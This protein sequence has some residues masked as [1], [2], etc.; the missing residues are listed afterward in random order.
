MAQ[1]TKSI[2]FNTV[3]L[4]E[5]CQ[6]ILLQED[7]DVVTLI[8]EQLPDYIPPVAVYKSEPSSIL[9]V[10][11]NEKLPYILREMCEYLTPGTMVY[12]SSSSEEL[13]DWIDDEIIE[14]MLGKDIDSAVC[15]QNNYPLKEDKGQS[16]KD[17]IIN[18]DHRNI[19]ELLSE[20]KPNY[21][22]ILTSDTMDDELADEQALK[23]LLYCTH[24]KHLHPAADFGIT[25]EMRTVANQQLAQDSMANDFVISRNIASL[26][27]AQ[28]A[29]SREL[30][31]IFEV[32]LR[33]EG[34]EIY[35]KPVK[36]YFSVRPDLEIDFYSV[37]DAVAEK[38]EIFIGYKKRGTDGDTILL[39]PNKMNNGK[40][41]G[42]IFDEED[43][44]IVLAENME[45]YSV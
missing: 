33:S 40:R 7:D 19:Y 14:E 3:I 11:C 25:C 1:K 42:M 9:I 45:V 41:T 8:E 44:L 2:N 20:C 26:M 5:G 24:Y 21:V 37:Q 6:L 15:I 10:G 31:E 32:L 43:E 13:K 4:K 22:L 36:Y 16:R 35:M 34:F 23:T 18:D 30:R 29:E 39:N 28:I 27:M 38:G 12:L 17:D